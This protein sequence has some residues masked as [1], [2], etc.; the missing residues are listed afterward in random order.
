MFP[1]LASKIVARP[2]QQSL[3]VCEST[4]SF[5]S[6]KLLGLQKA[7]AFITSCILQHQRRQHALVLSSAVIPSFPCLGNGPTMGSL[8]WWQTKGQVKSPTAPEGQKPVIISHGW[9]LDPGPHQQ[10][11]QSVEFSSQR[12]VITAESLTLLHCQSNR[13]DRGVGLGCFSS[14]NLRKSKVF[15][16]SL[17]PTYCSSTLYPIPFFYFLI[18]STCSLL[19]SYRLVFHLHGQGMEW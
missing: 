16:L 15:S 13:L 9:S 10:G 18:T 17:S 1:G 8:F 4:A 3:L 11:R 2:L 6:L 14:L 5:A 12:Q 19:S 7:I